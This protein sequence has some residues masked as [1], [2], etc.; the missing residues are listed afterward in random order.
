[1]RACVDL[2]A[3]ELASARDQLKGINTRTIKKVAEAKARKKRKL[4][5]RMEAARAKANQI[6]SSEDLSARG[7][8]RE[9][10]KL[11]AIAKRD[12]KFGKGGGRGGEGGGKGKRG[13]FSKTT[14]KPLDRRMMADRRQVNAKQKKRDMKK[15]KRKGRR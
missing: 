1:M 12:G 15:A 10:E 7:K 4:W 8:A 6:A 11:Y 2:P 5:K 13:T 9:I 3:N 14:G